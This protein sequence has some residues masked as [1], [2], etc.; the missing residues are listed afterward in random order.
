MIHPVDPPV[1]PPEVH[2]V[3]WL[4]MGSTKHLRKG[5]GL[6]SPGLIFHPKDPFV[7]PDGK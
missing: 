1:I 7:C 5:G 2:G 4:V 6:G 3:E